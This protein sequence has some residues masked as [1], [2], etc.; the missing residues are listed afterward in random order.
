[1]S[2]NKKNRYIP[3]IYFSPYPSMAYSVK[4]MAYSVKPMTYFGMLSIAMSIT[5]IQTASKTYSLL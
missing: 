5:R 2:G 1:M 3:H 4:P